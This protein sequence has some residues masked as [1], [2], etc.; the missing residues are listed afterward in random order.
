[1]NFTFAFAPVYGHPWIRFTKITLESRGT[2][3]E[4]I[5]I[6]TGFAFSFCT[7]LVKK[8]I[9]HNYNCSTNLTKHP[10]GSLTK[11]PDSQQV[12]F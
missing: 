2:S 11:N 7:F 8:I 4:S 9:M 6:S 10:Q 5:T 1:M 12:G 3:S